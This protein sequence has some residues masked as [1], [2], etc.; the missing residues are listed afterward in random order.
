MDVVLLS[1]DL[2]VA[3]RVEGAAARVR[4]S[5]QPAATIDRAVELCEQSRV[6]LIIVDLSAPALKPKELLERLDSLADNRPVVVAFGP[7]VH[8]ALL[9]AAREAGCDEVMSRGQF[10]GQLEAILLRL[11]GKD[12]SLERD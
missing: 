7:H 9:S 6:Q 5:L 11:I 10:L 3:S 1:S 2:V 12:D 4:A 8:E